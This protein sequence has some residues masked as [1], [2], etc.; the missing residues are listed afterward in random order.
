MNPEPAEK[1]PWA[2]IE[3]LE[4]KK[5]PKNG[6]FA[7]LEA[8]R[9]E[10]DRYL[11]GLSE[12]EKTKVRQRSLRRLSIETGIIERIY[13]VDWGLTLTLV[14]EGFAKDVIERAA[15]KIDDRTIEVLRS[16]MECLEG[17]LDFVRSER[18]LSTSFIKELHSA[19]TKTQASHVVRDV[20]GNINE[21]PLE[22]G[23]WKMQPNHVLRSDGKLLEYTPPEHV[24]TEMERLVALFIELD[25]RKVVHPIVKAAWFHHAFVRIHPFSDGNGRVARALTLLVLERHHFAPLVVDRFHR[26]DYLLALDSANTG[27]LNSLVKLFVRLESSALAGELERPAERAAQGFA[28][29][30]AH[31]LAEQLSALQKKQL[32]QRQQALKTRALIVQAR[33]EHWFGGK[34]S[35]LKDIFNQK[36]V[37][38]VF[39]DVGHSSPQGER[40]FWFR[41]SI[42]DSARRAGHFADFSFYTSW[43]SLRVRV[44]GIQLRYVASVHGAGKDAGVMAVTTFAEIADLIEGDRGPKSSGERELIPTTKDSFR[45]VHAESTDVIEKRVPELEEVLDSG[46]GIALA[47]LMRRL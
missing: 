12:D 1:I 28:A 6:A 45:F 19:L 41:R 32:T 38:G 18:E 21:I 33:I 46:L 15:G 3:P 7:A 24:A 26:E 36:K 11:K 2:K 20:R 31:T 30:V 37:S 40:N 23:A 29:D 43:T 27:D 17:V 34:V 5:I 4:D 47:S 22:H 8:L 9:S 25:S 14:A 44:E 13:D 10:W 16:Q 39:A 35:E 42:I